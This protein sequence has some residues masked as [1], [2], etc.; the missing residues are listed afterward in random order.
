L[1]ARWEKNL[2]PVPLGYNSTYFQTNSIPSPNVDGGPRVGL[3][4]NADEHTV[5]RGSYGWFY[6]PYAGQA[7]D[8]LMLG[9]NVNL[10]NISVTPNQTGA[11]IFPSV[12]P[13][14][15]S[16]PSGVQ[17]IIYGNIRLRNPRVVQANV[18]MEKVISRDTTLTVSL[19][20]TRGARL[21][22]LNDLNFAPPSLIATYTVDNIYGA[23]AALYATP[24][25]TGKSDLTSSHVYQVE[26]GAKSSRNAMTLQLRKRLSSALNFQGVYTWAHATDDAGYPWN[27]VAGLTSV[28]GTTDA[29]KG[30]STTDQRHRAVL[31]WTWEPTVSAGG[32]FMARHLLSGWALSGIAIAATGLP[33]TE[34]VM[35]Q[36]Q[37]ITGAPLVYANT[38]N[39]SGGWDRV[40]FDQIATLRPAAMFPVNARLARTV[41]FGEKVQA[42]LMFEAYNVANTQF[43]TSVNNIAYVASGGILKPAPGLNVGNASYGLVNGTNARSGQVALRIVF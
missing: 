16:I 26:S 28:P 17:D 21:W 36:G 32:S 3:A 41:R 27:G 12:Y 43:N 11:P 24:V 29:D 18:S 13:A 9:S 1:G 20:A 10:G 6:T 15:T 25:Y 37:Q 30:S 19:L 33:E 14:S 34:Q 31:S 40:P 42:Q 39:G 2:L 35:V 5:F 22:T 7:L 38:L 8:A 4:Y 23:P